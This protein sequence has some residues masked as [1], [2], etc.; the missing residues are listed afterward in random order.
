[1]TQAFELCG[2]GDP[3]HPDRLRLTIATNVGY[4][5]NVLT[6]KNDP[7]ASGTAGLN[8]TIS[9]NLGSERLKIAS[10][11]AL[12]TTYYDNRPGDS[13]DYNGTFGG[14]ISYYATRR[15]LLSGNFS[16]S[17]LSQP[18]PTLIGGVSRFQGDYWAA[19][20]GIDISYNIRPRLSARLGFSFSGIQYTDEVINQGSGFYQQTYRIGLDYLVSPR[21]T[22]TTEYRYSPLSYYEADQDSTGHILTVG[23]ITSI[24]P[25]L[26]WTLQGGVEA[27]QLQ[28]ETQG[29]SSEYLG[30]FLETDLAYT[31]APNSS[32]VGTL[33]YGTEPSGVAG[34]SVRETLR[35]SLGIAYAFTGRLTGSLSLSYQHDNYDQP[36]DQSDFAQ[37]FTTASVGLAFRINPAISVNANY[38]RS[39]VQSDFE[40]DEY[41]RGVT[42]L[43]LEIIF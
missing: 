29:G 7:I 11:L 16:I 33:R 17:Y 25:K 42:T 12:G 26:K 32:L 1:V 13:T 38:T 24:T 22:L 9:Y 19:N 43:G 15:L 2:P 14:Q 35:G 28:N 10:S 30:P 8:G 40:A 39:A 27:R 31:F 18:N 6:T 4:D 20:I 21:V 36:G 23:F 34:I 37:Q 3:N 41:T 5:D